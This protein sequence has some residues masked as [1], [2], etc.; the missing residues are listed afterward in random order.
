MRAA[1]IGCLLTLA[2]Q[3]VADECPTR[4]LKNGAVMFGAI[5][6]CVTEDVPKLKLKHAANVAAQW[7]DNDQNGVIDDP[8]FLS[9]LQENKPILLMS[10][11]GFNFWE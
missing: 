3:A 7:L 5:L 9:R 4:F 1:L 8:I 6:I 10:V 11:D 2:M